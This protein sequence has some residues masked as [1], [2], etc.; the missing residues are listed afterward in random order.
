M[1]WEQKKRRKSARDNGKRLTSNFHDSQ[2]LILMWRAII[3]FIKSNQ[4]PKKRFT[5][6]FPQL[7]ASASRFV[8]ICASFY[9]LPYQGQSVFNLF[10]CFQH[11]KLVKFAKKN[12]LFFPMLSKV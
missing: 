11:Q 8:S 9:S 1:G 4:K 12:F 6:R 2:D 3:K 5:F 7:R 10:C